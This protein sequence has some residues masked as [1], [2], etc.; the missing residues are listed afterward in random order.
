MTKYR[1]SKKELLNSADCPQLKH[2][3]KAIHISIKE[4]SEILSPFAEDNQVVIKSEFALFLENSVKD[5]SINQDLTLEFSSHDIDIKAVSTGIKNYYYNEF[6]ESE[7]K[8]KKNVILSITTFVV[9]L[10]AMA[11]SI[12]L[13]ALNMQILINTAINI[14][15]WVFI[16]ESVD[17][18]FFHRAELRHLQHRQMNFIKAK[19]VYK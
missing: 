17:L 3:D 4:N 6:V 2:Y 1:K 12:I 15:A 8:L 11:I 9:G 14:F 7:R 16:W 13:S 18:F 10:F 19:V 5:V